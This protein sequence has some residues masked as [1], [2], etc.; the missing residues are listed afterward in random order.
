MRP[1][2]VV[3]TFRPVEQAVLAIVLPRLC[4]GIP[5]GVKGRFGRLVGLGFR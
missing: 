3:M 2:V 4:D 1:A 5:L